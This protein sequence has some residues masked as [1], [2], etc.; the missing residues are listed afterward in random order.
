MCFWSLESPDGL[1]HFHKR[2]I[3][4]SSGILCYANMNQG[5]NVWHL[6]SSVR[7]KIAR[8]NKKYTRLNV[9]KA[10]LTG[11]ETLGPSNFGG[12]HNFDHDTVFH[13]AEPHSCYC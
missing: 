9:C 7:D 13:P 3:G 2:S 12:Y 5:L 11:L 6:K 10:V 1:S 4:V 8:W